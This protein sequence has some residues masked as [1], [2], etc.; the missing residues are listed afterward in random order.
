M[1]VALQARSLLHAQ[2]LVGGVFDKFL[3]KKYGVCHILHERRFA[4][5]TVF[6]TRFLVFGVG[7]S[8]RTAHLSALYT[9]VQRACA[10]WVVSGVVRHWA[11]RRI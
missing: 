3:T 7:E 1:D 5:D 4:S 6:G 8:W 9:I 10:K 2:H 11:C